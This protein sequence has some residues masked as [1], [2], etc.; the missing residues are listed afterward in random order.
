M[1]VTTRTIDAVTGWPAFILT[2]LGSG[3]VLQNEEY[4]YD[5]MGN[6]TQRQ[7]NNLGP[8]ENFY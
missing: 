3:S 7:N 2:G 6:V 8:T 1:I 5:H 4:M